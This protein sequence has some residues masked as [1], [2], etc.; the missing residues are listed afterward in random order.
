MFKRWH[1]ADVVTAE[2]R[3]SLGC[4][5]GG[6]LSPQTWFCQGQHEVLEDRIRSQIEEVWD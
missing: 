3:Y 1:D 2:L 5:G 6:R 4:L